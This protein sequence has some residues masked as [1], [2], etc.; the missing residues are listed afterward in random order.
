VA[1]FTDSWNTVHWSKCRKLGKRLNDREAVLALQAFIAACRVK[2]SLTWIPRAQNL[3]GHY[4]ERRF[5][6]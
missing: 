1:I 6:L 3:A 2:F 4:L 5:S